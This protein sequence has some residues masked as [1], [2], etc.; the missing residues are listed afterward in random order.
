MRYLYKI[1]FPLFDQYLPITMYLLQ[2]VHEFD[3]INE[4]PISKTILQTWEALVPVVLELAANENCTSIDNMLDGVDHFSE[5][6]YY[7]WLWL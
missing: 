1:L 5:Y 7:V 3:R 4:S 6:I 2:I